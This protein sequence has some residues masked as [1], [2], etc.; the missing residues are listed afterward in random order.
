MILALPMLSLS[1]VILLTMSPFAPSQE[2]STRTWEPRLGDRIVVDTSVSIVYLVHANGVYH[3]MQALTGQKRTVTY[4]G[5]RYFAATP[6]REWEL[7]SFERKGRS[8]TFGEGRFGRL[9]WPGHEDP[10]RGDESTAYGFH[11]H[12]SIERMLADKRDRTAQDPEGTGQRSMGCI[13]L[14]EEDLTLIERTWEVNGNRMQVSTKERID[15][16]KDF[17]ASSSHSAQ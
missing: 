4:D 8:T 6:L 9:S 10:R 13:L 17:R 15:T 7:R 5:I 12:R 1:A 11:S 14:S 3:A 16:E 2:L